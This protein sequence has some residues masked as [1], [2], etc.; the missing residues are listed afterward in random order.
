MTTIIEPH[1]GTL[2][3]RL[4]KDDELKELKEK[5]AGL[6][7][8]AMTDRQLCDLEMIMN[9][10]FSPLDGF[11]KKADYDSVCKDV[12]MADGTVWPMPITL[13]VSEEFAEEVKVGECITI[14]SPQGV[15]LAVLDIEDMWTPDKKK[16]AKSVYATTDA[17]HPA[18]DYLF[19]TAGPVYLGGT[20][21]GIELPMHFDFGRLRNTPRGLRDRFKR[22]GWHN[23]VAFQTRN[24]MHRAHQELTFRAAQSSEANL[25]IHPVVGMTKPGDIDHYSRVRCYEKLLKQYPDQTTALSLLPLAMRMGGPREA[26]WHAII[27]KN[28]GCTHFIVGRDH[29]GPGNDS[30]DKPFYGP[31]EAQDFVK[32]YE[33]EI[34]VEMVPF[35][36]MV[37]VEDRACYMPIDEV[38]EDQKT[39]NI[40]GTEFRR[41]LM[42]GLEIPDW[43]SYTEVVEELRKTHP[44]KHEQGFTIFFTG[45]LGAGKATIAN[46]LRVKLL[47]MGGRSIT[48]LDGKKVQQY[49][50]SELD[51]S[52]E[53]K[54][55]NI[56]RI[57]FVASEI[58]KAGGVA[59]CSPI[60]PYAETREKVKKMIAPQGGFL[61]VYVST[62]LDICEKRDTRGLYEMA[63]SWSVEDFT[64]ISEAYEAPVDPDLEIDMQSCSPDEAAQS[65]LIKLEKHGYIK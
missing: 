23:V 52:K 40:S 57:G 18:V 54:E 32:K 21:H 15:L 48:L 46:A 7:K 22:Q 47:E 26:L 59:I 17:L 24:P 63:R 41:R 4:L 27:R 38:D 39:L 31:Y 20:L 55:I 12:R 62:P 25:L 37:Y 19:N 1:G 42:E 30:K 56:M 35:R 43:F 58:T 10:A 65:I 8:L 13:D 50:S 49:L 9:G 3:Q 33:E 44:P 61:E 6:K 60:A 64:G 11:M 29:A 28:Y 14:T 45:L 51:A 16:E 2:Q 34:G 53:D 5:A 36:M